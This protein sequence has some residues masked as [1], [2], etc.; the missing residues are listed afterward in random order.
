MEVNES[1]TNYIIEQT[2]NQLPFSPNLNQITLITALANFIVNH[3]G[4]DVFILNGYAGTGKTSI[5]GALVKVLANIKQKF[6]IL[7]PTGRAAKVAAAYSGQKASTIHKHI[8]RGNSIDPSNTQ[9]FLAQNNTPDAIFFVDEASLISDSDNYS[10]S[11]LMQLCRHVYSA[12][13]CGMILIGDL[14]Q[15]PP[16]GQI[17]SFAMKPARLSQL[18]LNPIVFNLSEPARQA[19]KSGLLYNAT[20]IRNFIFEK[21]PDEKFRLFASKFKD[22]EVVSFNEF[23]D[24]LSD[25]WEKVGIEETL[26]VTRSN[27][28]AN[29]YNNAIR[30]RI[31]G[32]EQ[33]LEQGD[34]IVIAKNDYYWSRI[35]KFDSFIANGDIAIVEWVGNNE[36]RYGRWFADVELSFPDTNQKIGAKIMIRSLSSEGPA[37]SR[38]EMERFY[39]IV[40]D[41]YEGTFSQKI[42][43]ALED[44]YYNA[45]QAKYSYCV[46]CH[47]AQGGQWKHVYIDMAGIANENIGKEFYRWLYT[48]V[49]RA[50]EKI[51]LINPTVKIS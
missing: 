10:S 13:G 16:V 50:I 11:L 19:K 47:K 5:I 36:K 34:R 8:F 7:A 4:G 33:P 30:S 25:S 41:S 22:I 6:F 29:D 1:N 21:F 37:I 51:F 23:A 26:V 27:K 20:V 39:N 43:G 15:L 46:T 9:F 44:P 38:D 24:S 28:R 40:T 49:T 14:A 18:G 48:A 45:L 35:N 42:K 2:I 12:S 31:I 32:S 3:S 17:E